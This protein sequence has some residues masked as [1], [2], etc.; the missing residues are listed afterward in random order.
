MSLG[1]AVT[2]ATITGTSSGQAQ[3]RGFRDNPVSRGNNSG[4]VHQTVN[5]EFRFREAG[6]EGRGKF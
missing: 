6:W 2:A 4:Q 3:P 5:E 1:P